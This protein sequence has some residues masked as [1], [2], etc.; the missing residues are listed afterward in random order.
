LTAIL[1]GNGGIVENFFYTYAVLGNVLTR[2]YTYPLAGSA[3]PHA[4]TSIS[5]GNIN[6]TFTY[7]PN[8]NQVTGLGRSIRVRRGLS[9]GTACLRCGSRPILRWWPRAARGKPD[10]R[11][12]RSPCP[13][14]RSP[15]L[16]ILCA[17]SQRGLAT[18]AVEE[19]PATIGQMPGTSRDDIAWITEGHES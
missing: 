1:A 5:S 17:A 13:D 2:A 8:G 15:H 4:V 3:R 10:R 19:R 14:A 12:S 9:Q 18:K 16:G 6:T 11:S 7:D